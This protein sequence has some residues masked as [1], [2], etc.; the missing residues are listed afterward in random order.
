MKIGVFSGSF[1]PIH[2]G[3]LMLASYLVEYEDFD[4]VWLS[5]SPH[6]PLRRRS[7]PEGDMH[8]CRMVEAAVGLCRNLRFCDVEFSLPSPSYTITLL[9]TLRARHPEHTFVLIIGADNWLI[10]DRWKESQRIIDEYGVCI[11]PRMGCEIEAS[12]LPEN[13]TYVHAPVVELSS[14]WIRDGIAANR[15]MSIFL[16]AGVYG[17]IYRNKLYKEEVK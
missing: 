4:E 8:R 17:Y 5:V 15:N 16:P 1:N 9:D 2:M 6:N 13:V 10:F 12:A 7:D 14:T 11:Y 3:H